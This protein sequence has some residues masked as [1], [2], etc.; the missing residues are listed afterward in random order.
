M[1]SQK[2]TELRRSEPGFKMQELL[3]YGQVPASRH[4]QV[5]NILA[6]IAAMQPR[7]VVERHLLYK[8]NIPGQ[9]AQVGGSQSINQKK[10][11][12]QAPKEVSIAHL[13]CEVSQVEGKGSSHIAMNE[14]VRFMCSNPASTS[15]RSLALIK[16]TS[17]VG[18]YIIEGSR[19]I[20]GNVILLLHKVLRHPQPPATTVDPT[21]P[22]ESLAPYQPLDESGV[23]LLE[24]SVRIEDASKPEVV[25]QG[26]NELLSFKETMKGSVEMK[27][28]T[29]LAMD[30]RAR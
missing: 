21:I 26:Q 6:G 16:Y 30:T 12:V 25:T 18:E 19:F 11:Q 13:V 27:T 1:A 8:P 10:S 22:L 7:R 14:N 9:R 28:V 5:L 2:Q 23:Y 3:L 20:H 29:R 15:K 17:F 24:A 4:S